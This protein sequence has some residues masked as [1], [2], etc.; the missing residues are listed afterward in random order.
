MSALKILVV[1][2]DPI[3]AELLK[4]FMLDLSDDVLV[5]HSFSAALEF[6][7]IHPPPD[8]ITLDLAM[9]D[10]SVEMTISRIHEIR[11]ANEASVIIVLS[12][13]VDLKDSEGIISAGADAFWSKDSM[14]PMRGGGKGFFTNLMDAMAALVKQP[15]RYEKNVRILELLAERVS[16]IRAPR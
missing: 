3:L 13:V 10:S 9:Q 12:G 5:A 16:K 15:V 4:R 14:M 1:D 8:I 7:R 6:L 2:D 11:E